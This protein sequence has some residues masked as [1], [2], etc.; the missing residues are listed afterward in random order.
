MTWAVEGNI[1]IIS[2]YSYQGQVYC[3]RGIAHL[4]AKRAGIDPHFLIPS[5]DTVLERAAR[6]M[7]VDRLNVNNY[8]FPQ[9]LHPSE[10]NQHVDPDDNTGW[11]HCVDCGEHLA[12]DQADCGVRCELCDELIDT[13]E[14]G[15]YQEEVGEFWIEDKQTSVIAHA[16]CGLDA[17]LPLA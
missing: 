5:A 13:D 11:E 15:H 14:Y 7:G 16:Q 6:N 2:A 1:R 12:H 9:P 17:E 8:D 10:L 3:P 4:F